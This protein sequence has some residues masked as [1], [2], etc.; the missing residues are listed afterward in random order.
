[1]VGGDFERGL[2]SLKTLAEAEKHV[3]EL[4]AAQA[5]AEAAARSVAAEQVPAVS[6][7]GPQK[8]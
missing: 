3:A 2:A 8:D 5:A 7:P 1:M 6:A 4:A